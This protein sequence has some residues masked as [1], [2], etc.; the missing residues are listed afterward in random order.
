MT[1]VPPA[2]IKIVDVKCPGS[3]DWPAGTTGLTSIGWPR[4]IR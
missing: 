4:T 2:V 3:G 1:R